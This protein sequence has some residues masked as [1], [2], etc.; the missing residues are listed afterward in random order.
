MLVKNEIE[1]TA[2]EVA[3]TFHRVNH[4]QRFAQ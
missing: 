2:A 1:L 4:I 3:L